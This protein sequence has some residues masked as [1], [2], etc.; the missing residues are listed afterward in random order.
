[1]GGAD[2]QRFRVIQDSPGR[3]CSVLEQLA[4]EG[5]QVIGCEL[6]D[7]P[8]T[9]LLTRFEPPAPGSP[10]AIA[11]EKEETAFE[12]ARAG[13]VQASAQLDQMLQKAYGLVEELIADFHEKKER[14][15]Q[16]RTHRK[17]SQPE[18]DE[19]Q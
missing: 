14:R 17:R 11:R 6:R 13:G 9:A 10:E 2:V 18:S 7:N 3:L 1:M 16:R 8:A 12:E 4:V 15:T 5:W 19:V